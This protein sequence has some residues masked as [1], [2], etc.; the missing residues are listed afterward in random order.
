VR[1]VGDELPQPLLGGET[2]GEG[3]LDLGEHGV[4]RAAEAADLG[5]RVVGLDALREVAGGDPP[6][7][8]AIRSSGLSSRRVSQ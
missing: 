6:D 4:Q 3:A 2:L 1:G 5:T 8:L 7:F